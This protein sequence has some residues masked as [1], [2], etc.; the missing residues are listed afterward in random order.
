MKKNNRLSRGDANGSF[1]V[2]E[3]LSRLLREEAAGE[4]L[5]FS[6]QLHA[7]IMES[8]VRRCAAHATVAWQSTPGEQIAERAVAPKPIAQGGFLPRRLAAPTGFGRHRLAKVAVAAAL[9]ALAAW[10]NWD[11]WGVMVTDARIASVNRDRVSDATSAAAGDDSSAGRVLREDENLSLVGAALQLSHAV[12]VAG[13]PI[14]GTLVASTVAER[15]WEYW[16]ENAH[17][18]CLA[19][20]DPLPGAWIPPD[21]E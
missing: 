12:D 8:V 18:L 9:T 11:R 21:W 14:A 13:S 2:E 6:P 5:R 15:H 17:E 16:D 20:L 19:L 1:D 4:S 3:G 10:V 7:R